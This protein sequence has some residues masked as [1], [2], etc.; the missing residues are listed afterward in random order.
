MTLLRRFSISQRL[1]AVTCLT[2]LIVFGLV[3]GFALDF[4]KSLLDGRALKTQHIVEAG[5]G[6]LTYFHGL[7]QRGE[8]TE[9]QAQ[10]AAMAAL[11]QVRYGAED[12]FWVH[13]LD[14]RMI[15]HPFSKALV[16][17]SV[18]EVQD[19]NGK[20]LFRDM[21]TR[22][23][24]DAAGYVDYQWPKPGVTDP[25]AKIS[26]VSLFEPWGWVLGSGIYL[27]DVD[28]V[29]WQEMTSKLILAL[30]GLLV[31]LGFNQL[32]AASINRPLAHAVRA[33][34]DIS[35]GEGDLTQRLDA[36]GND[37]V[38]GLARGFNAFTD[39]LA[40]VIDQLREVVARN[41]SIAGDVGDA[42]AKAESSYN[43]QKSELDTIASAVEEMSATVQEIARR[44]S[45]SAEAAKD[46]S[47]QTTRGHTTADQT[48]NMMTVLAKEIAQAGEAVSELSENSKTIGSVLSVIR[49]VADQTN[50]LALN[51]AIEAARAGEQGRGF[52]VVA[53]EVRTLA[54]R[55]QKST[56]EIQVMIS[57]LQAG[58]SKAVSSMDDSHRQSEEMQ[59]QV[60]VSRSALAAIATSVSTITD[61]THQV[62]AAAEQ[63]SQTSNEIASSLNQLSALGDKVMFE[64]KDTAD[65]TEKLKLAAQ[66]LDSL[67]SQFKTARK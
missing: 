12:Y 49:G 36:S 55:T 40:G 48:S 9:A 32:I 65:N 56:D 45:D 67:V 50:L 14:L 19:P 24:A 53:D 60:E 13:S 23:R 21:N 16:G 7:Q 17:N 44:M 62:A 8:M 11:E 29:F 31:L 35:S 4:R 20:F 2:L 57:G 18:A 64:L 34:N 10:A 54:S 39:K 22:V 58:T 3:L 46:A 59:T 15:M 25:V 42:M 66:Q 63:Q 27:D 38:A 6:T 28:V 26:Y 33:M 30:I 37:E 41:H 61:M 43:Q 47:E 5:M 1:I 52:A 51:A